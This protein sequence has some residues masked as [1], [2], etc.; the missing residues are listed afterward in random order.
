MGEIDK[1]SHEALSVYINYEINDSVKA[2]C[3]SGSKGNSEFTKT[4]FKCEVLK[5]DGVPA[6]ISVGVINRYVYEMSSEEENF[7]KKVELTF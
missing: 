6:T 3:L 5:D 2:S 1:G 7:D 4:Y